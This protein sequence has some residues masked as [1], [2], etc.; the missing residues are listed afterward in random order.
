MA[1]TPETS[2][3]GGYEVR[4]L[5]VAAEDLLEARD[6]IAG[7]LGAPRVANRLV[8]QVEET[9]RSLERMPYRHRIYP[10]THPTEHEVRFGCVGDY[11]LLYWADD[12]EHR[13]IVVR[14]IYGGRQVERFIQ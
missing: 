8:D 10:V 5:P 2:Q 3:G 1:D 4:V 6:Y 9:L 14:F 12:V 13:V 11:L 7:R